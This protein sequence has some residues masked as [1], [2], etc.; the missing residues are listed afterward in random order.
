FGVYW[1]R[2]FNIIT[3]SVIFP[4]TRMGFTLVR[5]TAVHFPATF[6]TLCEVFITFGIR[7]VDHLWGGLTTVFACGDNYWFNGIDIYSHTVIHVVTCAFEVIPCRFLAI[8]SSGGMQLIYSFNPFFLQKCR[9][10]FTSPGRC[11]PRQYLLNRRF[12]ELV[13]RLRRFGNSFN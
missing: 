5:A 1:L 13:A 10:F 9:R 11:T 8:L 12:F 3:C 2:Y 4:F 6:I 7:T